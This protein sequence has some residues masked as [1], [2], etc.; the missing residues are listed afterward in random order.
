VI[1]LQAGNVEIGLTQSYDALLPD[2]QLGQ[3]W[4][5][6]PRRNSSLWLAGGILHE[7]WSMISIFTSVTMG[8]WIRWEWS[9]TKTNRIL[10]PH[11]TMTQSRLK[12]LQYWEFASFCPSEQ[13]FHDQPTSQTCTRY[14]R[15]WSLSNFSCVSFCARLFAQS[16]D[17]HSVHFTAFG[18]SLSF[19]SRFMAQ[20]LHLPLL[21]A[22]RIFH[23]YHWLWFI[24]QLRWFR[25]C[26]RSMNP[27][28]YQFLMYVTFSE[29]C[30]RLVFQPEQYWIRCWTE[31]LTES[32]LNFWKEGQRETEPEMEERLVFE[33]CLIEV[34]K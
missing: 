8:D 32:Q 2:C 16:T 1:H 14:L 18:N 25:S 24:S 10:K 19:K 11:L 31:S 30:L 23:S 12:E 27:S 17:F 22:E 9:L 29:P 21:S 6:E 34:W 20:L 3:M 33:G 7:L 5:I 4:Q 26:F 13:L 15:Y 28:R